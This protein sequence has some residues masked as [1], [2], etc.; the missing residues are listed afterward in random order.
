[1]NVAPTISITEPDGVNDMADTFYTIRWT[2]ADPD[3]NA[4]VSLYY[5]S[6]DTGYD[7]T[8]IVTG[9]SEDNPAATYLWNISGMLEDSYY[10][11]GVIADGVNPPDSDYS[12]GPL[13][14]EH[15]PTP[16]TTPP[17]QITDLATGSP[18]TNS[19]TL[20]WTAPG[21]DGNSGTAAAYDIRYSTSA[22]TG[23]NWTSATRVTGEPVPQAAGMVQSLTV[24]GLASGTTYYFRMTASDE[25]PNVSALSN[26][27]IGTTYS[28]AN[29]PVQ[30]VV[31]SSQPAGGYFWL[32]VNVGN[33]GN[34][35][36]DLF[37]ISFVV[38]PEP[39]GLLTVEEIV[40]DTT[41]TTGLLG[42]G[43]SAAQRAELISTE[44][45]LQGGDE[46][47][48]GLSR[49]RQHGN[50]AGGYGRVARVLY[51][52]SPGATVAGSVS[53]NL[54]GLSAYRMD[55]TP[56]NLS[57]QGAQI[58]VGQIEVWPGDTD[59][60]GVVNELDILPVANYWLSTETARAAG[61]PSQAK[62]GCQRDISV[63]APGRAL[64]L[65]QEDDYTQVIAK[66]GVKN[67]R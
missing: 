20:I 13:T 66:C 27:A 8:E 36:E 62:G 31:S 57:V 1:M 5:D 24:G 4:L 48:V 58:T 55:G 41:E 64:S 65:N 12:D 42:Q 43:L 14:I 50:L 11:Y 35:V 52:L 3:D 23:A 39:S 2:D 16:D 67:L 25:A 45:I 61:Y 51:H 56:V 54:T 7:G 21:D 40:V 30:V 46:A 26:E 38:E 60:N 9:L 63:S 32:E 47:R 17:A 10:I 19:F 28:A 37:G 34:P 18:T 49:R 59:N 15:A 29:P 6:D 53:F 44:E 33:A 22:I